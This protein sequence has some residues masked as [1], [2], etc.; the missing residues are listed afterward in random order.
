MDLY[1]LKAIRNRSL[2]QLIELL[3]AFHTLAAL[4]CFLRLKPPNNPLMRIKILS[5]FGLPNKKLH[6]KLSA[7]ESRTS[8]WHDRHNVLCLLFDQTAHISFLNCY[9]AAKIIFMYGIHALCL[10][11]SWRKTHVTFK[12][13]ACL[14]IFCM[15]FQ[16]PREKW[17]IELWKSFVAFAKALNLLEICILRAS[18]V[19][20][21]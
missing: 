6:V 13:Q 7:S 15:K 12:M 8:K 16:N 5:H 3:V 21:V 2:S 17:K 19:G 9:A 20:K 14:A 1:T 10:M 11:W 4:I 18:F